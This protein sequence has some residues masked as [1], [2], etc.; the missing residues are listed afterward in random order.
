MPLSIKEFWQHHNQTA[1]LLAEATPPRSVVV[2]IG[3]QSGPIKQRSLF[4]RYPSFKTH[5]CPEVGSTK[6]VSCKPPRL[7]IELLSLLERIVADEKPI[8][9]MLLIEY[10]STN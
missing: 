5:P 6:D 7:N 4:N 9:I 2:V 10:F 8:V 1:I 3:C